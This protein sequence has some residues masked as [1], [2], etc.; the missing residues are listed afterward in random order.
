MKVVD[1]IDILYN[2][3]IHVEV[4]LP[5]QGRNDNMVDMLSFSG[6]ALLGEYAAGKAVFIS[7]ELNDGDIALLKSYLPALIITTEKTSRLLHEKIQGPT[8]IITNNPKLAFAL[9]ASHTDLGQYVR[10][11]HDDIHPTAI[12]D[13][14][15]IL[16]G[17]NHIGPHTIIGCEGLNIYRFK[18]KLYNTTHVGGVIIGLGV[19]IGNNCS[20]QRAV[21]GNTEIGSYTLIAHNVMI[22]HGVVIGKENVISSGAM[23]S[24]SVTTGNNVYIGPGVTVKN[25]ISIG[26]NSFIGV[27]SNVIHDIPDDTVAA[28]NPARVMKGKRP[29]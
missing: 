28:G 24:G 8:I 12:I 10:F 29:W 23:I 16:Q 5:D 19:R 3:G 13:D 25:G 9:L 7:K 1:A 21:I 22:G 14:D 15:V 18:N 20:I 27:G 11:R 6:F 26:D 4:M 2:D 17:N